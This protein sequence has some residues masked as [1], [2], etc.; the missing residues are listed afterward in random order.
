MARAL[1]LI[2]L[3]NDFCAGGALAVPQ[4]DAVIPVANAVLALCARR[5]IPA[6]ASQ[7]WHPRDHGSFAINTGQPV[8]TLGVHE[9]LEQIWW[10]VHCVQDTP[11]AD[12]HPRLNRTDLAAVFRKGEQRHI[13]SYS[14]FFDNG[15]RAQTALDGWLRAHDIDRLTVL[16]LAMDY[17]VK[18]S[19]LDALHLGYAVEVL[20]DGCRGVNLQPEDSAEALREMARRGAETLTLDA[21][22]ARLKTCEVG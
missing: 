17:C 3:Q 10:P 5:S 9:G 21:F 2:D 13:D 14:T 18:Y 8:N 20:T 12:F 22:A 6:V 16:G 15:R 4:G 11:G 19:V 7:D 1:L